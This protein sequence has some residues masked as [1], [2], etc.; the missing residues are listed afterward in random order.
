MTRSDLRILRHALACGF[1]D[2]SA[3]F[4]WRTWVAGWLTRV[5][6]Q[7][8]FFGTI[9]LLLGDQERIRFL[10]VGGAVFVVVMETSISIAATTWERRAGTLP[11]LLAS[12]ASPLVVFFGRGLFVVVTG[13]VTATWSLVL[14]GTLFGVPLPMP[15]SLL[16]VPLITLVGLASYCLML[17]CGGLALRLPNLRNVIS[18]VVA[19]TLM[20]TCGVLVPVGFWPAWVQVITHA[21][22]LTH[23]L[24]AIRAL[25]QGAPPGTVAAQATLELVVGMVWALVAIVLFTRLAEHGRRDG[26]AEF[27]D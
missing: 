25:L 15:A 23:G 10:V 24:Q 8:T 19:W 20:V 21:L 9:G 14:V 17:C 12:P 6:A 18:N 1:A 13:T 3:M 22:P 16:A 11:L 7:V 26:S 5:L 27:T 4:T 2:Y